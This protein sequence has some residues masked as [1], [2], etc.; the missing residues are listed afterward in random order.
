LP[1]KTR[2]VLRADDRKVINGIFWRLRSGSPRA[3]IPELY[4]PPTTCAKRFRRW[5]KIGI[6]AR[7]FAEITKAYNGDLQMFDSSSIRVHQHAANREREQTGAKATAAAG[8][9]PDVRWMGRSRG[10]L[11][12][13]THVLVDTNGPPLALKLTDGQA[14]NG[15]S[16]EDVLHRI[17]EGQILLADRAY[18]SDAMRRTLGERGAWANVKPMPN[19]VNAPA[20]S[21]FLYSYRD[22]VERFFSKLKHFRA[23]AMR[24]EK[25]P[26]TTSQ[27]RPRP[28]RLGANPDALY[29]PVT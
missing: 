11:T 17:G 21:P 28:T 23:I 13:K 10:G 15:K 22:L 1:N 24:Y 2:G 29:E 5:R 4:G 12:T 25:T 26:N 19:R 7:I 14:H 3:E 8:H 6:W 9:V 18:D 27:P 20:F 16:A